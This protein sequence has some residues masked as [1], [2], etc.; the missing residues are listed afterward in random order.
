MSETRQ[1]SIN[2]KQKYWKM[3]IA[4]LLVFGVFF[5]VGLPDIFTKVIDLKDMKKSVGVAVMVT[6]N[7]SKFLGKVLLKPNT[8]PEEVYEAYLNKYQADKI[9]GSY[10]TLWS[11]DEI[12]IFGYHQF[13]RQIQ[14]DDELVDAYN[15]HARQIGVNRTK[16]TTLFSGLMVLIS[17]LGLVIGR[18]RFY[19]NE[20]LPLALEKYTSVGCAK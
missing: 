11:E 8:G 1:G 7:S 9:R 5:I 12:D 18:R 17:I 10:V 20:D 13:V 4:P 16:K 3:W 14:T 19:K 2:R 15:F 6:P